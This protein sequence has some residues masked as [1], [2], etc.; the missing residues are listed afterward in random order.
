MI[1]EKDFKKNII[2]FLKQRFPNIF[3]YSPP[4][5][6]A[7]RY[8]GIPDLLTSVNG[9]FMAIELKVGYNT[10][11]PL[12]KEILKQIAISGGIALMIRYEVND[13]IK[14]YKI[15]ENGYMR[16]STLLEYL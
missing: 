12:Q 6:Q 1:K 14:V 9:T 3:I 13:M 7:V 11:T 10:L 4:N 16:F 8:A 5:V 2:K 15:D